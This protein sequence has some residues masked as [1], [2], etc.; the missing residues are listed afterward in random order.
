MWFGGSIHVPEGHLKSSSHSVIAG[1]SPYDLNG[2]G[3][4]FN[5]TKKKNKKKKKK[6]Q[7]QN[8][9]NMNA[10]INFGN[11]FCCNHYNHYNDPLTK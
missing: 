5:Q 9:K 4:T 11:T 8:K 1:K 10:Y 6:K 2:I 7:K 3:V